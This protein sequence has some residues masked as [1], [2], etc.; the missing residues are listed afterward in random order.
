LIRDRAIPQ[1]LSMATLEQ[2]IAAE[3]DTAALLEQRGLPEPDDVEYARTCIRL[4]WWDPNTALIVPIDPPPPGSTFGEDLRG[5]D[6]LRG[7]GHVGGEL[8]EDAPTV[9]IDGTG[10]LAA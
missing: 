1:D 8:D 2:K 6:A 4:I 9:H 7:R 10:H 5:L 3:R